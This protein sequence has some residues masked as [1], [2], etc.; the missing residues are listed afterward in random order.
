MANAKNRHDIDHFETI[1]GV[2]VPVDKW[3]HYLDWESVDEERETAATLT[4]PYHDMHWAIGNSEGDEECDGDY[5]IFFDFHELPDGRIVLHA[6]Y[7]TESGGDIG[8]DAYNVVEK[9]C[10]IAVAQEMTDNAM[11]GIAINDVRHDSEGWN[12]DP[13]FFLRSVKAY[14]ERTGSAVRFA[15]EDLES[16]LGLMSWLSTYPSMKNVEKKLNNLQLD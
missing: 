8:D 7:N 9:D 5:T 16:D 6:V 11:E 2:E 3:G 14:V 1:N 12:Q 10:A 4:D 13:Y 15:E